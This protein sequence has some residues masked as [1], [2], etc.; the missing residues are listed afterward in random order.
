MKKLLSI[1]LGVS[2][3]TV[4]FVGCGSKSKSYTSTVKGFGGDVT[5]EVKVSKDGE[6]E[7]INVDAASETPDVG[8]AAAEELVKT[9]KET[10]SL[11]VDTIT[12][13]TITS[14]AVI[15]AT[16]DALTEA[17]IELN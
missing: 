1:I 11:E 16:G 9:I 3:A 15:K 6:L 13:A 10:K 14:E 2:L 4:A 12:G 17:G 8:G 5:V 7:A